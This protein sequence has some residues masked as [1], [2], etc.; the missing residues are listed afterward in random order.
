MIPNLDLDLDLAPSL[1]GAGMIA[2]NFHPQT[3]PRL[4]CL[5]LVVSMFLR[6][7]GMARWLRLDGES[8]ETAGQIQIQREM[9]LARTM[10]SRFL[11]S[12]QMEKLSGLERDAQLAG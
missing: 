5:L 10:W 12:R 1:L 4:S 9:Y 2:V 8:M 3:F 7:W 11:K 6:F